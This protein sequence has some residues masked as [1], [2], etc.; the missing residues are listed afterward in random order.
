MLQLGGLIFRFV[1]GIVFVTLVACKAGDGVGVGG[2]R[3]WSVVSVPT[4]EALTI[5]RG[6]GYGEVWVAGG[7]AILRWDNGRWD[8]IPD[9]G[10]PGDVASGLWVNGPND[11]WLGM[12]QKVAYHWLG[13]AWTAVSLNDN[14]AA[15]VLWGSGPSDMWATDY[16]A[17]YLGHNDGTGWNH[18]NSTDGGLAIW[19]S[20]A[21]NVWMIEGVLIIHWR[22][23]SSISPSSPSGLARDTQFI[24]PHLLQA[25][26]GSGTNDI[27]AVGDSGTLIHY[28]GSAWS[29]LPNSPTGVELHG[30]WGTAANDV[31][32]VGDNGILLHLDNSGWSKAVSP[33]TRTLRSVWGSLLGE[34]WAVGDSATV[35]HYI[36]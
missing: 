11:V 3:G 26:W 13:A 21:D 18:I 33:T 4:A 22:G 32:A 30:V 29:P 10:A 27:W 36:R 19:G 8:S 15:R 5:V 14:R 9:P 20:G 25:L 16:S 23:A 12:L 2:S 6:D 28:D 34:V 1:A 7:P 35:L 17:G 24:A 31:W